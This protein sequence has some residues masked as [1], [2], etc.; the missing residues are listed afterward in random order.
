[1]WIAGSDGMNSGVYGAEYCML[2]GVE[3]SDEYDPT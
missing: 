2:N 3:M 1:M